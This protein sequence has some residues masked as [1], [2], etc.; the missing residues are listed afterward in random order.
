MVDGYAEAV[1]ELDSPDV[2][3]MFVPGKLTTTSR[4]T[5]GASP[6]TFVEK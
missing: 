5:T 6:S 3:A 4:R 1:R 2:G